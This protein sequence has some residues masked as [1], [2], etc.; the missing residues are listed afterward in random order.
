VRRR[1]LPVAFLLALLL[2]ALVHLLL[3]FGTDFSIPALHEPSPPLLHAELQR[4]V[5]LVPPPAPPLA[6][7]P[8]KPVT[9]PP[10]LATSAPTAAPSAPP[11]PAASSPAPVAASPATPVAPS[12]PAVT[13]PNVRGGIRYQWTRGE[14]GLIVGQAQHRWE[15]QDGS[16]RM[17]AVIETAGLAALFRAVRVEQSSEGSIDAA[18][19]HPRSFRVVQAGKATIGA[20]FADGNVTTLGQAATPAPADAQDLLSFHYQLG[21][22]QRQG[23]QTVAVAT[24]KKFDRIRFEAV[25]EETLETPAGTF[26]TRHY[27]SSGEDVTEVW[28]ALEYAGLPVKIRFTDRKG[29]VFDQLAQEIQLS[30]H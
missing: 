7:P 18:G 27:R 12:A 30:T 20:D 8:P 29:E 2:S 23:V 5:P 25:G 10:R 9:K 15:V 21:W 19:F 28:S 14:Q 11:A 26:R 6:A 3:L 17:T 16:Y 1:A 13:I 4:V 24:G 22:T